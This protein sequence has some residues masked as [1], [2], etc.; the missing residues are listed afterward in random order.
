MER[1]HGSIV[2]LVTPFNEDK[3]QSVNYDKIRE[4]VKFQAE[5]GTYAVLPCGTTGESPT[6]S[7][8]E[9]NQVIKTTVEA[10]REFNIKVIAGTGSNSTREAMILTEHA[11]NLGVDAV[12]VVA[13]YYNKPTPD[14]LIEHF[15]L[16]DDLDIPMILYNIPGRTGINVEPVTI[17]E[18]GESCKNLA[19]L[20]ASN[21]DLD[22]ITETVILAEDFNPY[23]SVLSG[24]DSL[25]LPILS[26]GGL[27]VVSVAANI[28]PQLTRDLVDF[29]LQGEVEKAQKLN[30]RL[31]GFS[32]SL[33][34]FGA[35]PAV[36]KSFMNAAGMAAGPCRLPLK[37][38]TRDKVDQITQIAREMKQGLQKDGFEVENILSG[39]I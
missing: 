39:L 25:T 5:N 3:D 38:I 31:F 7:I 26:V 28:V 36:I 15:K 11:K 1:I 2:A 24:D 33:L 12:L 19:G 6:L 4:L 10:A 22:Q 17:K 13:P 20:K 16:L 9:H 14:G 34:K 37:T 27:G 18:I 32:R 23:F 30:N 35:N 21:G 29:Y 8:D